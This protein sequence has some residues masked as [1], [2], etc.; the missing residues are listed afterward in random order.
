MTL[1]L[2]KYLTAA[3]F[4]SRRTVAQ[5]VKD[6]RVTL[7][8]EAATSF[9]REVNPSRDTVLVDGQKV[10]PPAAK[11]VYL[12]LNKPPGI[13]STTRDE[14]GRKT[15]IDIIPPE[16]RVP[17]LHP[18][19]RLD[20]DSRGL[21][22]LTNDGDLTYRLTHPSFEKEKEYLVELDRALAP[23]DKQKFETGLELEDGLTHPT[24]L[25]DVSSR[26]PIYRVTLHEGRKR[27]LRRMFQSLGY[28]VRDLKRT[29]MGSL[30]LG[31]LGE[32]EMRELNPREVR[33]LQG[34]SLSERNS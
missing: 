13:L 10:V 3:G 17:D 33:M 19:G 8:G 2:V 1:T 31:T 24:K 28:H 25:A 32:G 12:M 21:I 15:I 16:F 34:R 11:P 18:V 27:Q 4:G 7:N 5:A 6:G 20:L 30:R 29:R 26:P 14:R 22:L 9:S 23:A